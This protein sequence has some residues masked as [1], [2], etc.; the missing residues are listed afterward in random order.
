MIKVMALNTASRTLVI[1]DRNMY[2]PRPGEGAGET[3]DL[4]VD[5]ELEGG[6]QMIAVGVRD[7]A[8]GEASV[9]STTIQVG[10]QQPVAEVETVALP[11]LG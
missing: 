1:T 9:V 6:T 11:A 8:S 10:P 3:V 4:R 5:L 7:Q 2:L